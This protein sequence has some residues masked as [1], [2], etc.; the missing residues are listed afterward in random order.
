MNSQEYSQAFGELSSSDKCKALNIALEIRKFEIELYWKRATYFWAFIAT[1]LAG[2]VAALTTKSTDLQPSERAEA[3][4]V[5]SCLGFVFSIAWYFV[6]RASK[7]WQENWEKH[8]D[9]LEDAVIGPLYKTVLNDND[10]RFWR[11][12]GPYSFS[13]SKINQILSLF[14][15]MIFLLLA[16]AALWKCFCIGWSTGP[17]SIA[18]VILTI[19]AVVILSWKG[20]TRAPEKM[21]RVH[22][23]K[24]KT[25]IV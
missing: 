8:V 10:L 15:V 24:R 13:V 9:L 1:A 11:L 14:V 4:I 3:L 16:G 18:T 7:F 25:E 5:S 6:N 19:V 20:Q 12:W 2:Y 22:A 17:F 21:S 23:N